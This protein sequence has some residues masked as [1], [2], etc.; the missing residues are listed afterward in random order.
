MAKRM[1]APDHKNWSSSAPL[2]RHGSSRALGRAASIAAV[3]SFVTHL[4]ALSAPQA[5]RDRPRLGASNPL[6]IKDND[7]SPKPS[8]GKTHIQFNETINLFEL[9]LRKKPSETEEKETCLPTQEPSQTSLPELFKKAEACHD[10]A[11]EELEKAYKAGEW[12]RP[13][14]QA[15]LR[16]QLLNGE[17]Q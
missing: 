12:Q 6:G 1:H 4:N 16:S 10:K 17:T 8:E 13:Y 9:D 7:A 3:L 5:E 14:E 15:S 11:Q 2:R